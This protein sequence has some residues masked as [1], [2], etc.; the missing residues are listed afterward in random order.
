LKDIDVEKVIEALGGKENIVDVD[1]CITR[2]R[3]TV[4]DIE[5]VA[6]DQLWKQELKAKG[7]FKKGS[8]VQVVYG[9]LA[10]ILKSE[11]NHKL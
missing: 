2:L 9:A 6:S 3:V 11:I 5:K 8:G 4:K 1:A 7:V 10:E